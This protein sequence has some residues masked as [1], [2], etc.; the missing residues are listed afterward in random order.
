MSETRVIVANSVLN[1]FPSLSET[2]KA[3]VVAVMEKLQA[4]PTMKSPDIFLS[5][6]PGGEPI[7]IARAGKDLRVYFK[8]LPAESTLEILLISRASDESGRAAG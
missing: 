3:D 4:N 2:E 1:Q 8:Y 7:G 5:D 6:M